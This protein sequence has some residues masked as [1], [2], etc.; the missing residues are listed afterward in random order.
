MPEIK[1][2]YSQNMPEMKLVGKCYRES[3]KT[4]GTFGEQWRKWFQ[5]D[6]F[7]PLTMPGTA[8]PFEDCDAYIGLCRCKMGEPF[9]YWIG[10]FL[11]LS[12]PAP[13]GYDSVSIDAGEIGVAWVYGKEPDI[14]QY[15][16]L[17][18]L[19][20]DGLHWTAD[21]SGVK[22]CFERYVRP[23]FTEPDG[24]GNVI[25]DMCYYTSWSGANQK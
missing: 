13:D 8:Q 20:E 21:K 22:W 7:A 5:N 9:Q 1:R 14:Y 25:L 6:W 24:A 16:C 2:V 12:F 4:N 17:E 11:P 18:R 19:S 3:E 23:R 10:V 15:C